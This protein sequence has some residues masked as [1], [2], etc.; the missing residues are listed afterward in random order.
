MELR[1]LVGYLFLLLALAGA[2]T[3]M[4]AAWYYSSSRS[5]ARQLGRERRAL[6]KARS[7]G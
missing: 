1:E 5:Y 6:R 7:A 3:G 4:W 2:V